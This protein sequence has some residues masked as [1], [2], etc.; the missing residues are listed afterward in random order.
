MISMTNRRLEARIAAILAKSTEPITD[1]PQTPFVD[2]FDVGAVSMYDESDETESDAE[3]DLF[4]FD[5]PSIARFTHNAAHQ[6]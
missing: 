6:H 5:A 2:V 3:S 1:I 4:E